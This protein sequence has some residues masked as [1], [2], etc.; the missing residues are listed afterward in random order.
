MRK[1]WFLSLGVLAAAALVWATEN[2]LPAPLAAWAERAGLAPAQ[3][4]VTVVFVQDH[5]VLRAV[6]TAVRADRIAV[7]NEGGFAV[8][9]GRIVAVT[10]DAA[11]A[12]IAQAGWSE[13]PIEIASAAPREE[14]ASAPDAPMRNADAE[15]GALAH[16]RTLTATEAAR[17]LQLLQ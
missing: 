17:A 4:P 5:A 2:G 7:E 9:E 11:S 1:S 6:R 12:L 10:H 14:R 16:K 3:P 8:H 13:R 15:L